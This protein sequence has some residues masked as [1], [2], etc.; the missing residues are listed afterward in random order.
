YHLIRWVGRTRYGTPEAAALYER[1]HL[2]EHDFEQIMATRELLLR[3]RNE[4]HFDAGAAQDILTLGEQERLSG[5]LGWEASE[6][7]S[8]SGAVLTRAET[9]VTL[10]ELARCHDL[11]IEPATLERVRAAM[12]AWEATV[13]TRRLFF[14]ALANPVGLGR[15]V[16]EMH[17][18]GLLSRLIPPFEH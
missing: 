10:F 8:E 9:A 5:W 12:S 4:L 18:V 15:L 2:S 17:A 3:I 13:E 16:R 7:S 1:G 6:A 11:G 14:A